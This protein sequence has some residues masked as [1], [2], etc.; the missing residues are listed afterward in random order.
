MISSS[1]LSRGV[2]WMLMI[3]R[4]IP[5]V[6]FI[7][8]IAY[9]SPISSIIASVMERLKSMCQRDQFKSRYIKKKDYNNNKN[10]SY[11]IDFTNTAKTTPVSAPPA[12]GSRSNVSTPLPAMSPAAIDHSISYNNAAYFATTGTVGAPGVNSSRSSEI[13]RCDAIDL[14]KPALH[15]SSS[16]MSEV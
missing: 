16:I 7:I 13:S 6:I 9:K 2:L 3:L 5:I 14:Y 1:F 11:K 10:G 8:L 4:L 15:T 12:P